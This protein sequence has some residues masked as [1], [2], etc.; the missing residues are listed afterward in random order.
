MDSS[1]TAERAIVNTVITDASLP[2]D[3]K[4]AVAQLSEMSGQSVASITE[5]AL[6]EYLSWRV[7]QILDLKEAIAAADR[8]DFA[9]DDEVN[10]FFARH[11][12]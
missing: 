9:T 6:R 2:E 1:Q 10:A 11:G 5:D 8:E 4:K 3:L 7:P 12:R